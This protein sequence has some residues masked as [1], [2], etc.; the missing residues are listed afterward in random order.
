MNRTINEEDKENGLNGYVC[1]KTRKED[2]CIKT[3]R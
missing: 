2:S 1:M 3:N